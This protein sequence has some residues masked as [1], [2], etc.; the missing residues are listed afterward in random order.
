[1]IEAGQ[2][3]IVQGYPQESLLAG[4]LLVVTVVS[5][6]LMGDALSKPT[7]RARA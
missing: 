3:S 5:F 6:L 7:N 4:A 1:M 2:A